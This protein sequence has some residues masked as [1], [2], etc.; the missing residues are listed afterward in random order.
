[1]RQ[2]VHKDR[3]QMWGPMVLFGSMLPLTEYLSG[4]P[5]GP[6]LRH[7]CAHSFSTRP[8]ESPLF[9]LH[10]ALLCPP[11]SLDFA[12]L[13]LVWGFYLPKLCPGPELRLPH[14]S[15]DHHLPNTS[16]LLCPI[17]WN[18][19]PLATFLVTHSIHLFLGAFLSTLPLNQKTPS[20]IPCKSLSTFL[21]TGS[22]APRH[23]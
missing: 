15:G 19:G 3:G 16:G 20:K 13:L 1:M 17:S 23:W 22:R 7:L 4:S 8:F 18:P 5:T 11:R 12:W 6:H 2:E 21:E 14:P 10:I 9:K